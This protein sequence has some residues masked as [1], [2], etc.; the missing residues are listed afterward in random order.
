[1]KGTLAVNGGELLLDALRTN[2][3]EYI[4]CCPGS[5]WVCLLDGLARHY[6]N[7]EN[8]PIY[9]NCW[10]ESVAVA[11]AMGYSK[12]TGRAPAVLL[13]DSVGPLHAAMAIRAAYHAGDPLLICTGDSSGKGDHEADPVT[14]WTWVSRLADSGGV[15]SLVR[16][17]VKWSRKIDSP[18]D[19]QDAIT[20]G[21]RIAGQPPAGPVLIAF[22]WQMLV[23]AQDAPSVSFSMPTVAASGPPPEL[24]NH[25]AAV[26]IESD[27]PV[28]ITEYG[29]Q[30]PEAVSNLV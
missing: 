29:A 2:H 14:G 21:C 28:I 17:Y 26:L 24:L 23:S 12:V 11:M 4:F 7:G 25:A 27:Q 8:C 1:M 6:S 30:N 20:K 5:E 18:R 9:I 10:H 19:I 3:I 16:G 13:H 22:S 15:E